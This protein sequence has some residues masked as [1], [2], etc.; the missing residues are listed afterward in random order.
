MR[1]KAAQSGRIAAGR[2]IP[3]MSSKI[4]RLA[5]LTATIATIGCIPI[6]TSALAQEIE[7]AP[8]APLTQQQR[9]GDQVLQPL[10]N[11]DQQFDQNSGQ[12]LGQDQQQGPQLG[13]EPENPPQNP[14]LGQD[15]EQPSTDLGQVPQDYQDR[16]ENKVAE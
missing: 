14:P 15:I 13:Q 4:T 12:Q 1:V 8:L 6:P 10:D 5:A 3:S 9:S 16:I 2:T 11:Q 7:S